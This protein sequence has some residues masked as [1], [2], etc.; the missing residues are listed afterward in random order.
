M[1]IAGILLAAGAATRFGGDKLLATLDDGSTIGRRSCAN[2]VAAVPEVFAVV[3]AGDDDLAGEFTAAGAQTTV[4]ADAQAGMGASLAHGVRT[5]GDADA[6]IVA[7]AD[8]PWIHPATLAAVAGELRRGASV[9]VPRYQGR[10]GH[11]VGFARM[12]FPEL[13]RLGNDEGARELI[14]KAGDVCWID[15]DDPGVLRDV[16]VPGDLAAHPSGEFPPAD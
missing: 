9:V 5:A 6:V 11:P 12:H 7:L 13:T 15:V 3:R 1:R 16:D 10:R 4:C 14:A 8:M 2:L